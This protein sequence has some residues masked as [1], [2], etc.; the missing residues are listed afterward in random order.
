M[1]KIVFKNCL[2]FFKKIC[3][4]KLDKKL[5]KTSMLEGVG[6]TKLTIYLGGSHYT[7]SVLLC[8]PTENKKKL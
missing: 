8:L 2:N 5:P 6:E 1:K 3:F 7:V 4:K